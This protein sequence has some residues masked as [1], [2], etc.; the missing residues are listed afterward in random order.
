MGMVKFV[1][2]L[3]A[4]F[5]IAPAKSQG[6]DFF[7]C[8]GQKLELIFV[9]DASFSVNETNFQ[10]AKDF[11]T[12]TVRQL[13]IGQ[14][15]IRVALV[16]FGTVADVIFGLAESSDVKA[17]TDAVD[18]MEYVVGGTN[19]AQALGVVGKKVMKHARP[20]ARSVVVVITDGVSSSSRKTRR[21]S[22]N[23]RDA[24][25]RIVWLYIA[26]RDSG[27]L[28]REREG[29]MRKGDT[30]VG[31]SSFDDLG[32]ETMQQIL[33]ASCEER[34]EPTTAAPETITDV[35]E[36]TNDF[37]S[38]EVISSSFEPI[39]SPPS[40]SDN[41]IKSLRNPLSSSIFTA[42]EDLIPTLQTTETYEENFTL[43]EEFTAVDS[44]PKPPTKST[45]KAI[46]HNENSHTT[47][48]EEPENTS[49][50]QSFDLADDKTTRTSYETTGNNSAPQQPGFT[51][52]EERAAETKVNSEKDGGS[53]KNSSPNVIGTVVGVLVVAAIAGG[54]AFVVLRRRANRKDSREINKTGD[55]V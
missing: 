2:L 31:V 37:G 26:A 48:A 11:I 23:L 7:D 4:I 35:S 15:K 47:T 27:D 6:T 20:D 32:V 50:F 5:A 8:K 51:G 22:Q 28:E 33:N 36:S 34:P 10:Q 3:C 45:T 25:V 16:R 21:E 17:V 14:D 38:G 13:P 54:V 53:W 40:T 44:D 39:P 41:V 18:G 42:E 46:S 55:K 19:T 30:T 24:Q 29:M 52:A 12:D 43:E 1:C 9:Q 49:K